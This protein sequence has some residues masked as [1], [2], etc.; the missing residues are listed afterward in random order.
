MPCIVAWALFA[1]AV[2]GRQTAMGLFLFFLRSGISRGLQQV[3]DM[4]DIVVSEAV[5]EEDAEGKPL[6]T[7]FKVTTHTN[8][9]EYKSNTFSVR[10]R[11]SDF[12][13]LRAHLVTQ[14]GNNEKTKGSLRRVPELPGKK[15]WGK[16]EKDFMVDTGLI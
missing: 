5:T 3:P 16:F 8:L 10:R 9:P 7:T 1:S 14:V 2:A 4:I 11:Y 12:E 6:F 15:L 13:Y